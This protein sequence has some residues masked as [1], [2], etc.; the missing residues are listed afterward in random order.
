MQESLAI[1][2]NDLGLKS[3]LNQIFENLQA[4]F[5]SRQLDWEHAIRVFTLKQARVSCYELLHLPQ[6]AKHNGLMICLLR[7]SLK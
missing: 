7:T 1:N 2:I 6:I 5:S 4:A 3:F